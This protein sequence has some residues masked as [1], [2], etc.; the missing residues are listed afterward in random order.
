MTNAGDSQT[1]GDDTGRPLRIAYLTSYYGRASDT[2]IRDEI[3]GLRRLGHEVHTFSIRRPGAAEVADEVVRREQERTDYI[4]PGGPARLLAAAARWALRHPGRWLAA[5]RLAWRLSTPGLKGRTWPAAYLLE[6]AYLAERLLA[7]KVD[8]LHNHIGEGSA[9]VAAVASHLSGVPFSLTIHGPGE[10]DIPTLLHLDKKIARARFTVA[11]SEYG[12]S[13][14]Y[15]WSPPRDWHRIRIV[16]C[17]VSP[18]FLDREPTPIPEAPRLVFVGRL[19]EQKGPLILIEAA[20]RLA[21][22]GLPFEVVMIGDGPMRNLIE[23]MIARGGLKG[24]IRLA[25]WMGGDGVRE[26]LLSSRALVL[27]S[28][29]EGLPVVLM[30]SL[31][32]ARP[33]ITTYVAGI[34]E[35]VEPGRCGWLVPAGA[36]E[37]LADAMRDALTAP[38]DRLEAMGRDG[39]ARVAERHDA[40]KEAARLAELFRD[41]P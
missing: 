4:L 28:F 11:I 34:P 15:R 41:G 20:A 35:L 40:R 26:A 14:L 27:P 13:Q 6:A 18:A 8:H 12:R 3:A 29:A 5:K 16:R 33:A 24:R 25:G 10:F 38:T 22:E 1:P 30:E 32:L 19:A 9:V 21:R 2:F 23:E 17:G 7:L 37:P 36:V 31:A 39:A